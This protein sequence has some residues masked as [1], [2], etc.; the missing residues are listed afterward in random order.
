MCLSGPGREPAGERGR[1]GRQSPSAV[2]ALSSPE[3]L[4]RGRGRAWAAAPSFPPNS[5]SSRRHEGVQ[6]GRGSGTQ[7]ALTSASLGGPGCW[8]RRGQLCAGRRVSAWRLR[9]PLLPPSAGLLLLASCA[10]QQ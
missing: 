4:A 2:R 1:G 9:L 7:H 6:S 8:P 3:V 10:L 5:P